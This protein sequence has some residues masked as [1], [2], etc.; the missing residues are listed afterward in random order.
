MQN[1]NKKRSFAIFLVWI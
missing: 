1:Y